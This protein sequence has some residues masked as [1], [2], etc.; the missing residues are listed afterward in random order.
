MKR[1]EFLKLA[2]KHQQGTA[3]ESE[4][5]LIEK[6][7]DN[8]QPHTSADEVE[9]LVSDEKGKQLF[10]AILGKLP[11]VKKTR[12]IW[13]IAKAAAAITLIFV[14]G[15]TIKHL[16]DNRS[17]TVSTAMGEQIEIPLDDGSTVTLSENSSLTYPNQFGDKRD[18]SLTGRA[19]FDIQ[20]DI[21]R[22]F[23]VHT[24]STV[25]KVLGTSFDV[26]ANKTEATTVSVISGK[27]QVNP[28]GNPNAKVLLTKNQQVTS[29]SHLSSIS[30]FEGQQPIA[31]TKL[32]VF[33]NTNLGEA[34]KLLENRFGL[35][36]IFKSDALKEERITG[37]FKDE[38][39]A[40]IL[41][42]ISLLKGF[43][44]EY[45]NTNTI[46]ISEK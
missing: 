10:Q 14:M 11:T 23:T 41:K 12:P 43:S 30:T 17:T 9:D 36:I 35:D 25:V 42:S 3:T 38:T 5:K 2:E 40:N 44:F 37:K 1:E 8:M 22:P 27:V 16:T 18:V 28:K 15:I 21:E 24:K 26:D 34:A 45:Q 6:F 4:V 39:P 46:T 13:P 29:S 32:I 33:N 19:F 20:R 7:Y 31:W